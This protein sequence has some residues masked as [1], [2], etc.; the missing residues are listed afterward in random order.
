MRICIEETDE[1][2]FLRPELSRVKEEVDNNCELLL[3]GYTISD[4]E[5]NR[6]FEKILDVDTTRDYS[7]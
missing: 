7:F 3:Y 4:G 5:V 2:L 6:K 1:G